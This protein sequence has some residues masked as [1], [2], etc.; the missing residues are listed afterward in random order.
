MK[1]KALAKMSEDIKWPT[2]SNDLPVLTWDEC[3][4]AGPR[5]W[6]L[7]LPQ[8]DF[9]PLLHSPRGLQDS[10]ARRHL[11][12]HPRR[13]H[14]HRRAPR[15]SRF[16]QDSSRQGCD[17]RFLRRVSFLP[18]GLPFRVPGLT[19]SHFLVTTT[20]RTEPPTS[21]LSFALE[22]LRVAV[23]I[24]ELSNCCRSLADLPLSHP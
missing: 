14:L 20:T 1:L 3:K 21:S 13:F 10:R 16:D 24:A 7:K 9:G 2:S 17:H 5:S 22:S 4:F 11:W 6:F 23:S 15:R 12:I 18:L 19:L 8:P